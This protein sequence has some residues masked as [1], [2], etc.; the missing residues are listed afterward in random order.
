MLYGG[1]ILP[2]R[3]RGQDVTIQDVF[4]AIGSTRPA[5]CR[6]D[7]LYELEGC[8]S[9]GAGACGAQFTAN[10]MACA[11]E[12]MGITPMGSGMVPP[13]TGRASRSPASAAS[14]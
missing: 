10:T 8:A 12:V 6:D 2:G 3:W 4:E 9:P 11:F 1:S 5:R 7:D 14:W 13:S